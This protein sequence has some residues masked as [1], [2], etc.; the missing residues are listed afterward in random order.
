MLIPTAYNY[1]LSILPIA[2]FQSILNK[3]RKGSVKLLSVLSEHQAIKT[4]M[5]M[6]V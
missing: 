3:V 5:G 2:S 1:F 6:Q 4:N